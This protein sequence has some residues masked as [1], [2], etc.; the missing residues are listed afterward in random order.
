M[1]ERIPA[2]F[3]NVG[4][5]ALPIILGLLACGIVISGLVWLARS[6]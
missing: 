2:V 3:I 4:D 1:Y 6:A 5:C